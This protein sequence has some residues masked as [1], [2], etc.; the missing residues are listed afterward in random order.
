[1]R[2]ELA[3]AFGVEGNGEKSY[4]QGNPALR[5]EWSV[6]GEAA[7]PQARAS[8]KEDT[9]VVAATYEVSFPD[10]VWAHF[11]WDSRRRQ[12]G[13]V[14]PQLE[15]RYR[16]MLALFE[17]EHGEIANVYWSQTDASAVA[18]TVK[19]R[20][21]LYPG[22][23]RDLRFHRVTDWVTRTTPGIPDAL[24]HCE[25]LAMKAREV[26]R[27]TSEQ[28]TMQWIYAVASHLLGF[29]ERNEGK[30]HEGQARRAAKEAHTELAKLE[31]Y[32]DL[33]GMKAGRIVYTGGMILGAVGL[34]VIAFLSAFVLWLFGAY[35][36]ESREIQTFFACYAAGA[37]GAIVSVMSRMASARSEWVLDYEIGRPALR[38]LGSF[39]PFVGAI[40]GLA[41][42]FTIKAGLLQ[43][44][45]NDKGTSFY[46]YTSLA[47]LAGFSERF[48]KVLGDSADRLLPGG[49][50]LTGQASSGSHPPPH[51]HDEHTGQKRNEDEPDEPA[52]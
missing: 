44:T 47:F 8:T 19:S 17:E 41:L 40:F 32:Y 37:L 10:L 25:T 43:I 18:V 30:P 49:G 51:P 21:R 31:A 22:S 1:V 12:A 26:L 52:A 28:I 7:F 29:I 4:S 33:A 15:A 6:M 46:W 23:D 2:R 13:E 35:D 11:E 48:T 27:G 38:F 9:G 3:T 34:V 39:R 14:D 20:G 5:Q 24:N 45:P 36:S 42:Y 50:K 16:E